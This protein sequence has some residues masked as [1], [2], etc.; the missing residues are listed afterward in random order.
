MKNM[1]TLVSSVNVEWRKQRLGGRVSLTVVVSTDWMSIEQR[2][3]AV[4]RP[5]C[6]DG[7]VV[8]Q[9]YNNA[10]DAGGL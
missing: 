3:L 6:A 5:R 1:P 10:D 9:V 4:W 2:S 8:I 7:T